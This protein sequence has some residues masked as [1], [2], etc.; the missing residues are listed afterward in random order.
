MKMK[1]I[2]TLIIFMLLFSLQACGD[3]HYHP[4]ISNIPKSDLSE[5]ESYSLTLMR[6]EEKLARDVY[7][8]LG[9]KWHLQ[10]FAN[11]SQS[12]QRHFDSIGEL[13]DRYNLPDPALD[14]IGKFSD[15]NLQQ[16]YN[17]LVEKGNRSEL[18]A[19]IVGATIEDLD[20]YDLDRFLLDVDNEDIKIVYE[21]LLRGSQ[22]HIRAFYSQIQLQGGTYEAQYIS[23]EELLRIINSAHTGRGRM[24]GAGRRGRRK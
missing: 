12:E 7:L 6:E 5:I 3:N 11:I 2:L 14:E 1:K 23:Q 15:E 4:S 8:A 9:E 24:H 10:T 20:I 21:D 13:L 18:D 17:D 22:N 16:I 19:L